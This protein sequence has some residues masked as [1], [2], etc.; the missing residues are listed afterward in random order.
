MVQVRVSLVEPSDHADDDDEEQ[1]EAEA[2]EANEPTEEEDAEEAPAEES[3]DEDTPQAVLTPAAETVGREKRREKPEATKWLLVNKGAAIRQLEAAT[4]LAR[5]EAPHRRPE[6]EP[7][8]SCD[9]HWVKAQE[10]RYHID[11]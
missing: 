11:P 9:P 1:E 6:P 10:H 4:G 2:V 7:R 8:P 5:V 3:L